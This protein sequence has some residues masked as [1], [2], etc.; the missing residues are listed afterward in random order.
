MDLAGAGRVLPIRRIEIQHN[1]KE[2]KK[3]GRR[4]RVPRPQSPAKPQR[5]IPRSPERATV[6][7]SFHQRPPRRQT[8]APSAALKFWAPRQGLAWRYG[9][10]KLETRGQP[11]SDR[12]VVA[13]APKSPWRAKEALSLYVMAS[14]RKAPGRFVR[15]A[16]LF[17]K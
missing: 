5:R 2:A 3:E 8:P 4:L 6:F 16:S 15:Q 7:F 17:C 1:M 13:R 14:G 11:L 9:N 12:R 10:E